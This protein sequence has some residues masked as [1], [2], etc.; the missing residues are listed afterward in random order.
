ASDRPNVP[1][2]PS[3]ARAQPTH[4]P[5]R[6]RVNDTL[7]LFSEGNGTFTPSGQELGEEDAVA[8][9][10]SDLLAKV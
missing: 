8:D 10:R 7:T 1:F 2:T 3:G 9:A 4:H 6:D 5:V